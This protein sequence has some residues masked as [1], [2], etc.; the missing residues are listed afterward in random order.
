MPGA[1]R[2]DTVKLKG[3]IVRYVR[4]AWISLKSEKTSGTHS[5]NGVHHI[6]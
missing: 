5:A 6:Y 4:L 1:S 3:W 2:A